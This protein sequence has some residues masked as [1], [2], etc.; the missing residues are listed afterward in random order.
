MPGV[1]AVIAGAFLVLPGF[2]L[3]WGT[4]YIVHL[5]SP[6]FEQAAPST[7]DGILLYVFLSVV[8][9]AIA[10]AAIGRSL[11]LSSITLAAAILLDHQ[12]VSPAVVGQA[13]ATA[14]RAAWLYFYALIFVTGG[15]LGLLVLIRVLLVGVWPRLRK[16]VASAS[17]RV[18]DPPPSDMDSGG[19]DESEKERQKE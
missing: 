15:L 1:G 19:P 16:A 17:S 13:L 14:I 4:A 6:K 5:F 18:Q 11:P 2:L 12:Q 8:V 3:V 9:N 10:I 7:L